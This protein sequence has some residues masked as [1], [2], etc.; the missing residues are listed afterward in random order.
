MLRELEAIYDRRK[1]FYHKAIIEEHDGKQTLYSYETPVL[2]LENG[3][4]KRL[5]RGES[6]TTMRHIYEFCKQNNV[7]MDLKTWRNL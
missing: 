5:W 4:V 1:S 2:S 7:P 6:A 3:K